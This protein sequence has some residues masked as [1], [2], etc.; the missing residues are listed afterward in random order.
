M[1]ASRLY[2]IKC[3]KSMGKRELLLILGFAVVGT[4]VYQLT[5]RPSAESASH[6]SIS[7]VVNH[8]RR[9]VR[10]NQANAEVVTTADHPVSSATT[11]VRVAFP[12]G[13]AESLTITGEDRQDVSSELKVWSNGFD[14]AEAQ[15]LA[16][17]TVLK[18]S[19]AGGRMTFTLVFPREARQ[20]ATMVLRVPASMRIGLV[21]YNGKLVISG[22]KEVEGTESRGE[23]TVR[24]ITGKVTLSHRGG[25]L[26]IAD[27][28]ALKLTANGTEVKLSRVRGDSTIQAR[29]GDI[30]ASEIEG[31]V[32]IEGNNTD[33][34]ID[35]LEGAK[36]PVHVTATNGTVRIRGAR[37]DTRVDAR[38]AAV[39]L[40]VAR[41]TP[42]AVYSEGG[43]TIEL[44]A[45]RGGYQLDAVSTGGQITAPGSLPAVKTEGREQH[46][47]G[48]V[49]GG[50][51]T[52]TLRSTEGE[53]VLRS[54]D[55]AP[56][57]EAPLPP[58]P[59][60]PPSAP[61]LERKLVPR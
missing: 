60:R 61:T 51:P 59:P 29:S 58:R 37:T 40:E 15:R 25:E 22:T 47:A 50:G 26:T 32:D 33:V 30:E 49:N 5:A 4:L 13:N 42:I 6:F 11:E 24:D 8:L 43:E 44:T 17:G 1:D 20:R 57:A 9:A 23:A 21:R 18:Q 34:T 14:E 53:I 7:A 54:G 52:I 45:P 31:A 41:P 39:I 55:E 36:A 16:K 27:V 2:Y 46:A 19:E 48:P 28:G 38:N 35:R 10:G 3:G 56:A 12:A